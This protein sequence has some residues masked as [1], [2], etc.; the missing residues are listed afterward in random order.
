MH[1]LVNAVYLKVVFVSP[2][3]HL[4]MK[5]QTKSVCAPLLL[6][7]HSLERTEDGPH[8]VKEKKNTLLF[9]FVFLDVRENL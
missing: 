6:Q 4:L 1:V 9:L 7:Q 5:K 8:Y 2:F 3:V